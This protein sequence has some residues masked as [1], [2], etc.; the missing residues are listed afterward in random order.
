MPVFQ[1]GL[2]QFF[3]SPTPSVRFRYSRWC[4]EV[5]FVSFILHLGFPCILVDFNDLFGGGGVVKYSCDV[6]SEGYLK[7]STRRSGPL[8]L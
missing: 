8:S 1:G 6:K 3:A 7:K 2:G 5:H 4:D